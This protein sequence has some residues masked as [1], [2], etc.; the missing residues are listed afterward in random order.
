[1]TLR[2]QF[3]ILSRRGLV[4]DRLLVQGRSR[5]HAE[6]KVRQMYMDCQI[7]DCI[8]GAQP[9]AIGEMITMRP[10]SIEQPAAQA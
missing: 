10:V 4:I 5:A 3:R 6:G 8:E 2:Y 7:L 1:M 9:R